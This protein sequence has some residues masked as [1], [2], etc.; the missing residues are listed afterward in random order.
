MLYFTDRRLIWK[1]NVYS[2]LQ[3]NKNIHGLCW[4][5]EGK[6]RNKHAY[7]LTR[8]PPLT[9]KKKKKNFAFQKRDDSHYVKLEL[10]G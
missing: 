10:V 8:V 1:V 3:R 6:K 4:I 9:W 7:R 5:T 2:N